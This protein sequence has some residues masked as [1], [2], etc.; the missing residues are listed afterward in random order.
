LIIA[1]VEYDQ[2]QFRLFVAL[3]KPAGTL[4]A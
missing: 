1:T 2:A 3:G 4:K